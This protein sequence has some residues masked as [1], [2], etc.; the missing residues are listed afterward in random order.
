M[1]ASKSQNPAISVNFQ[2]AELAVIDRAAALRGCRR[3]DFIKLAAIEAAA[4]ALAH[5]RITP[6][7]EGDEQ[8]SENSRATR[9]TANLN[10][11]MP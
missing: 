7:S 4:D 5:P 6:T 1:P 9:E 3:T 8:A 10:R 11:K 2:A